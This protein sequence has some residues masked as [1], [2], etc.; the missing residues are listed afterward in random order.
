MDIC[1][2]KGATNA[3]PAFEKPHATAAKKKERTNV[4]PTK[5]YDTISDFRDRLHAFGEKWG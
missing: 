3:L 4:M 2:T 1:D 5:T